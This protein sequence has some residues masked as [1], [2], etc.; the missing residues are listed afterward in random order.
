MLKHYA[1]IGPVKAQQRKRLPV[2]NGRGMMWVPNG[3]IVGD[4]EIHID[5]SKLQDKAWRAVKNQSKK[6][7]LASGGIVFKAINIRNE[8]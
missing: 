8:A 7:V 2:L 6:S 5:L 3:F 1:T 4:V